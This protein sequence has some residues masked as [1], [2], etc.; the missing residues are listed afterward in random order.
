MDQSEVT[1]SMYAEFV[2]ATGYLPPESWSSGWYAPGQEGRPVTGVSFV[3][4]TFYCAWRGVRLPTAE[5]WQLAAGFDDGRRYP[6]GDTPD[7]TVFAK[8]IPLRPVGQFPKSAGPHGLYDIVGNAWEWTLAAMRRDSD[9]SL[10]QGSALL[11][12]GGT[13]SINECLF[14]GP[15][16]SDESSSSLLGDPHLGSPIMV[17]WDEREGLPS[18]T[19]FTSGGVGQG[20]MWGATITSR[21]F[22]YFSTGSGSFVFGG[23]GS[24]PKCYPELCIVRGDLS[25]RCESAGFRCAAY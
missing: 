2:K 6:W 16:N 18:V 9:H 22:S 24:I 7:A 15:K 20:H 3:D 10:I 21:D 25:F 19:G 8:E 13:L 12:G 1:N 4:A 23:G 17:F 11:F 5:E 14:Y